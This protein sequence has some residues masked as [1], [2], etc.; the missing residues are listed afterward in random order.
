MCGVNRI[1]CFFLSHFLSEK[2]EW[3]NQRLDIGRESGRRRE[4]KVGPRSKERRWEVAYVDGAEEE[5]TC[6]T[7]GEC[8]E[9]LNGDTRSVF[10]FLGWDFNTFLLLR[11]TPTPT[12]TFFISFTI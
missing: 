2:D 5:D 1:E 7:A 6:N 9:E 12:P 8:A 11:P 10:F 3:N 4:R